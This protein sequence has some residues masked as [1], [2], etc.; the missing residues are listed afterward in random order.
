MLLEK[1]DDIDVVRPRHGASAGD[2]CDLQMASYQIQPALGLGQDQTDGLGL[3]SGKWAERAGRE[4]LRLPLDRHQR[5]PEFMGYVRQAVVDH[6]VKVGDVE[7]SGLKSSPA[8]R[9]GYPFLQD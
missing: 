5:C 4:S 7:R 3:L 9:C 2:P 6:S 8:K 1:R